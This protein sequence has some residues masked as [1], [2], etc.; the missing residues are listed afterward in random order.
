MYCGECGTK[1]NQGDRFCA[2]CG[3]PLAQEE[4]KE[5]VTNSPNIVTQPRQPMS[6]K[7]KII[8]T[9]VTVI[10]LLLGAGYKVGSDLTS[11]K[12]VADDYIQASISQDAD[13][14]YKYL[15]IE[16][17]TT[18]V[19]KKI[20][21]ELLKTNKIETTGIK[22]YKITGVEYGEGKLTAEVT[23][24]Y[25]KEGSST[26]RTDSIKLT[27]QKDKK[28]LIFDNWEIADLSSSSITMENYTIKATKGSTVTFA[29]I[30]LTDKYLDKDKSTSYL[31]VYVLPQ[32]FTTKTN[33][34][35]VL[36][37]GLEIEEKV[38]PSAYYDSY[39]ISFD[40]DSLTEEAKQ[41]IITKAKETLTTVYT[42][43]INQTAF[44]EFKSNFAH[45]NLDLTNLETAYNSLLSDLT[46]SSTT[47]TSI[48]FTDVSIYDLKIN[49]NGNLEVEVK[50][51]YNYTVTYTDWDDTVQTKENSDYSYMTVVLKYDK[52][53]YYVVDLDDLED[54][55]SKY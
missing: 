46:N 38:T 44:S 39:T 52:G 8:I 47:L 4:T 50:T 49:N 3:K 31:D 33:L 36:T 14:L 20:F 17:D 16:G 12:K 43:A 51:K 40:E 54:Y 35:A 25:T 26:E 18:F 23:F 1:N 15:K 30:K 13:K 32:V 24:T 6:K 42:N 37:N 7:N 53:T 55:F 45:S 34:K 28:F 27:K 2:E 5:I 22:N 19:S 21:K 41:K 29:G 10:I 48:E 9:V 11:P